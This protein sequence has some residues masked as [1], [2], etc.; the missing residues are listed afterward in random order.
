MTE[1]KG[2]QRHADFSNLFVVGRVAL[3][4]PRAQRAARRLVAGTGGR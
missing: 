4:G 3:V 1:V 2:M